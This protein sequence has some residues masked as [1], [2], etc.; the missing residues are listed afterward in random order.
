ME[1]LLK[2]TT[3]NNVRIYPAWKHAWTFCPTWRILF[4]AHCF[5]GFGKQV[6]T[7]GCS[8]F[9][10][11]AKFEFR[12][13]HMSTVSIPVIHK[14]FQFF[15]DETMLG[16]LDLNEALLL[17]LYNISFFDRF[18]VRVCSSF[19]HLRSILCISLHC[20]VCEVLFSLAV[21]FKFECVRT[22]LGLQYL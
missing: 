21:Q 4:R 14:M 16:P 3:S 6:L 8:S 18:L 2:V 22:Y 5:T 11:W 9:W 13:F 20:K 10:P 19:P 1:H 17:F 7:K 15:P 12:Y